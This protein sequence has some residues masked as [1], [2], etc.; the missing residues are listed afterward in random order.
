M[1]VKRGSPCYVPAEY[2]PDVRG[3]LS[4]ARGKEK[5][6]GNPL[7]VQKGAPRTAIMHQQASRCIESGQSQDACWPHA[8]WTSTSSGNPAFCAGLDHVL[9]RR[10]ERKLGGLWP[11]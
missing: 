7:F 3:N 4:G 10:D 1:V 6:R 11:P 8:E 9:Q 2:R 5:M